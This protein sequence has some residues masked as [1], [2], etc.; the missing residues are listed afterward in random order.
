MMHGNPAMISSKPQRRS[1][2]NS[3]NELRTAMNIC[4]E[5]GGKAVRQSNTDGAA[6]RRLKDA[7]VVLLRN[8]DVNPE[9]GT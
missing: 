8:S 2:L 5:T 7:G 9:I 6:C 1:Q 3:T 4:F